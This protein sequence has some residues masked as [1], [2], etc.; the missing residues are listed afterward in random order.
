MPGR[1]SMDGVDMSLHPL[2]PVI[3]VMAGLVPAIH[4][5]LLGMIKERRGCPAPQTSLRSLRKLDCVA[6]HDERG[7]CP[8]VAAAREEAV[9]VV[10]GGGLARR[11]DGGDLGERGLHGRTLADRGE[12]AREVGMVVPFHALGVVIARP[13]EGRNV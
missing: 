4:V 6:G 8:R 10:V 5:C 13:G 2:E 12:P 7:L 9:L 1:V 3:T 11:F